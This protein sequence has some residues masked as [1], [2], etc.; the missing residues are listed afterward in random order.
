MVIQKMSE[1]VHI[2]ND[3]DEEE[4]ET[5]ENFPGRIETEIQTMVSKKLKL[6]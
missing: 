6:F 5:V 3:D 4:K 2:K 1:M